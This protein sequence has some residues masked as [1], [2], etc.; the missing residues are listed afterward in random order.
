MKD[1]NSPE[2]EEILAEA[3]DDL[4]DAVTLANRSAPAARYAASQSAEKYLRALCEA[5]DRPAGVM[6][7]IAK[8]H[9]TVA[10]IGAM[11]EL[12]EAVE[13]LSRFTT[14]AR[15]GSAGAVRMQQ[16]LFAARLV[17]WAVRR[18]LGVEEQ[19]PERP[20]ESGAESGVS[21]VLDT[22]VIPVDDDMIPTVMPEDVNQPAPPAPAPAPSSGRG[23]VDS[24]YSGRS[25][26]ERETSFVKMFLV[27]DRCGVRI[28]RTRQT[29]TGRVPCS[30]CGRPMKLQ[31]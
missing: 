3:E 23:D 27:C 31:K 15:A 12:G 13:L 19:P 16:V 17:R 14:P 29:A 11:S 21:E 24:R 1:I 8:L 10:D 7:D 25:R 9:D 2:V 22:A 20:P 5:A 26:Q 4:S 30:M 18:E 6:W 28:P